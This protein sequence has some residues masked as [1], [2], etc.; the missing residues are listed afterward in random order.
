MY[1]IVLRKGD[2]ELELTTDDKSAVEKQLDLIIHQASNKP[3]PKVFEEFSQQNISTENSVQNSEPTQSFDQNL[4][5]D[6]EIPQQEHKTPEEVQVQP[7]VFEHIS[8]EEQQTVINQ[9][10]NIVNEDIIPQNIDIG[11]VKPITINSLQ[12]PE[13][14]P[15]PQPDFDKILN[16]EMSTQIETPPIDKDERFI[17]YVEGKSALDKLDFLVIT[18]QYLAQYENMNTFNLKHINA[19]LMQNFTIIVDHSILQS[20][21]AREFI[22]QIHQGNDDVSSEYMLTEKGLRSY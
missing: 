14:E 21:I 9:P 20:A 6:E 17:Q 15:E 2:I 5:K 10:E 19:K 8:Q 16:N 11:P 1:T 13:P 12:N 4:I 3:K 7:V 18:A 22:T